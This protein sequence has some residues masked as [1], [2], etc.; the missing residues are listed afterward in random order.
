M[1]LKAII[2]DK[3]FDIVLGNTFSEEFNETLDSATILISSVVKQTFKP[4]DLVKILS[5][6]D[7]D[8]MKGVDK[9]FYLDDY[10]ESR[11]NLNDNLYKYKINLMSQAKIMEKIKLPNVSFTQPLN[12]NKK[13]TIYEIMVENLNRYNLKIKTTDNDETW[14]YQPLLV[15]DESGS[16]NI[17]KTTYCPDF[18]LNAPSLKELFTK[19]MLVKDCIPYV[20]H[21]TIKALNISERKGTFIADTS[22]IN[23]IE[24]SRSSDNYTNNLRTQYSN[25][26]AEDK[27]SHLIENLG[28]RNGDDPILT[29]SNMRLETRFPIYR[30]NSIK[31]CYYKKYTE[32]KNGIKTDKM[33]LCKQDITPLVRLNSERNLL[34][35]DYLAYDKEIVSMEQMSQ[36]KLCTV[37]YDIGSNK[38]VGWGTK[39]TLKKGLFTWFD[40]EKTYI[41]NIFNLVDNLYKTGDK[42]FEDFNCDGIIVKHGI[43]EIIA[44]QFQAL[45]NSPLKLKSL[46]FEVDYNGMFNG[47]LIHSKDNDLGKLTDTDNVS[48]SLTLLESSGIFEKE[49]VNRLGNEIMRI[50]ARY[51][52][53]D[54]IQPLGSVY[55]DD[56]V[57]YSITYSVYE[58][59]VNCNYVLTK[60]YVMK[61]Y[62]TSVWAKDRPYNLMTYGE[63]ISRSENY[64]MFLLL[65]TDESIYE[66]LNEVS[67]NFDNIY[68]TLVSCFTPSKEITTI[69]EKWQSKCL[70]LGLISNPINANYN[71]ASDLMAFVSGVSLCF[72]VSM[73]D[74]VSGGLYISNAMPNVWGT[75]EYTLIGSTEEWLL[76]VDDNETGYI[77]TL[78][79]TFAHDEE[80]ETDN[81]VAKPYNENEITTILDK[82]L[83]YPKKD[84]NANA[85]KIE[86]TKEINKDNK[87]IIDFTLQIEPITTNKNIFISKWFMKLNDLVENYY[88]NEKDLSVWA[89]TKIL[90][91]T[92][93][94]TSVPNEST[95]IYITTPYISKLALSD[96]IIAIAKTKELKFS[97]QIYI[98]SSSVGS[99][100]VYGTY[101][102]NFTSLT[103]TDN[104]TIKLKGTWSYA[105]SGGT[106]EE[107]GTSEFTLTRDENGYFIGSI[108]SDNTFG[109][110]LAKP[111]NDEE[112]SIYQPTKANLKRDMF[113]VSRNEYITKSNLVEELKEEDFK[114]LPQF[115]N[116]ALS[117]VFKIGTTANGKPYLNINTLG[118]NR[119][120]EYWFY[121]KESN[122][123][124]LVFGVNFKDLTSSTMTIWLSLIHDYDTKVYDDDFN[125]VGYMHNYALDNEN[126]Y[127]GQIYDRIKKG[128]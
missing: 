64:K 27:S 70:N 119:T 12:I 87:E 65:S 54:E 45:P 11:L 102:V 85:K 22:A 110:N 114:K 68:L 112:F 20:D 29:I 18:T 31:M 69:G 106:T 17:F 38:I 19:L 14:F 128:E 4:F 49:K 82:V 121:N 1:K 13:K 90:T 125:L 81:F 51:N 55:G 105:I 47:V 34:S 48:G 74:N 43:T 96:S 39:H 78:K 63:S 73:Y 50:N 100:A 36:Y 46:F 60:D 5:Y 84:L 92:L 24:S 107:Q 89:T 127:N 52:S 44:P 124:N 108:V 56:Y 33:F 58:D 37:G 72:S 116:K 98:P 104:N 122:S 86:I 41:E 67:F 62:F 57:V 53:I 32:I 103:A 40:S 16:L 2:N 118:L 91:D 23:Y 117:D 61:N 126:I 3:T 21:N 101:K 15:L 76:N 28:F 88:K 26:L 120:A 83:K 94:Y 71:Y 59:Y 109:V 42:S 75:T 6:E 25:A 95:G 7:L 111:E 115:P 97:C 77:N 8:P 93:T 113:V 123:Y 79:F 66:P 99:S 30:I 10:I 9:W 35:S 80:S